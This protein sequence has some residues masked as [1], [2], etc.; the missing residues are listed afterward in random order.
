MFHLEFVFSP[1]CIRPSILEKQCGEPP[2][3]ISHAKTC[4]ARSPG[5]C[6]NQSGNVKFLLY[7]LYWQVCELAC[8]WSVGRW[9][10]NYCNLTYC[11]PCLICLPYFSIFCPSAF[12]YFFPCL[13]KKQVKTFMSPAELF[14]HFW[15]CHAQLLAYAA[16]QPKWLHSNWKPDSSIAGT[17]LKSINLSFQGNNTLVDSDLHFATTYKRPLPMTDFRMK[18]YLVSFFRHWRGPVS[19]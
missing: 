17:C 13:Y 7:M 14:H 12:S 8:I 15:W 5:A 18:G 6:Y 2:E 9:A 11:Y 16:F 3:V 4:S 10:V 19:L 1:G